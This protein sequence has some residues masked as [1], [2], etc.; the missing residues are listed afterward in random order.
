M[1]VNLLVR[2]GRK[3]E[4]QS[5]T[6]YPSHN[7]R[8]SSFRYLYRSSSGNYNDNREFEV[9]LRFLI[10]HIGRHFEHTMSWWEQHDPNN[11][12]VTEVRCER[13]YSPFHKTGYCPQQN[14]K[15]EVQKEKLV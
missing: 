12:E 4:V 11:I 3:H 2:L 5:E 7:N 6:H 8:F 10:W 14:S 13:C 9:M 15:I 1:I